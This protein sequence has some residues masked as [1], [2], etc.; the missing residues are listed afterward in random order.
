[1]D[2]YTRTYYNSLKVLSGLSPSKVRALLYEDRA[3]VLKSRFL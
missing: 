1:M 2:N 3:K